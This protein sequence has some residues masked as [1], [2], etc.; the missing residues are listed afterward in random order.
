V[1]AANASWGDQEREPG[2]MEVEE[3]L[4]RRGARRD[5]DVVE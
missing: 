5:I 1:A 2:E 4:L 3:E